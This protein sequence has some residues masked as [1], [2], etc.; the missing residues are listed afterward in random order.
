MGWQKLNKNY[1]YFWGKL[2]G[3]FWIKIQNKQEIFYLKPAKKLRIPRKT[4][5][6]KWYAKKN[7][8]HQL[9]KKIKKIVENGQEVP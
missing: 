8:L 6:R 7:F 5:K 1:E 9:R 3:N 4:L 2:A